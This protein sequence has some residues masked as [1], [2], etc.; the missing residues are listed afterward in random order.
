[1]TVYYR[2]YIYYKFRCIQHSALSISEASIVANGDSVAIAHADIG[3]DLAMTFMHRKLRSNNNEH[4]HI[5][6]LIFPYSPKFSAIQSIQS[7][8]HCWGKYLQYTISFDS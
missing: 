6:K 1:M 8:M 7:P 5:K 2:V 3:T 4:A